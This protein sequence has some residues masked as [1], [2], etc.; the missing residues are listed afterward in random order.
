MMQRSKESR[1]LAPICGPSAASLLVRDTKI[2][3][4]ALIGQIEVAACLSSLL[5]GAD[6]L[7][8][9]RQVAAV[10]G[11]P[12]LTIWPLAGGCSTS[13]GRSASRRR[14]KSAGSV[15][16]ASSFAPFRMRSIAA[17]MS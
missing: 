17:K 7:T 2:R 10:P 14:M 3:S 9:V 13:W 15:P 12:T 1:L 6:K 8:E 16:G 4:W 5:S 11:P